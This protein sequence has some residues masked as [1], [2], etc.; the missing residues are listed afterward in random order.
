[1]VGRNVL[2]FSSCGIMNLFYSCLNERIGIEN[3]AAVRVFKVLCS[4][5][6]SNSELSR[7]TV[8]D[9]NRFCSN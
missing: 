4:C 2:K 9:R 7:L 1:M 3:E 8:R 6:S 5:L